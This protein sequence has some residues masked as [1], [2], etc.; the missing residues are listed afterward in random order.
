MRGVP[1]PAKQKSAH[2]RSISSRASAKKWHQKKFLFLRKPHKFE[3][4]RRKEKLSDHTDANR[5]ESI[6][7]IA[8]S[9][10]ER[11]SN[12]SRAVKASQ[13]TQNGKRS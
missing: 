13:R 2:G 8:Q 1:S 6:G 11:S 12:K 5:N 7:E 3:V 9:K 10:E 4:P